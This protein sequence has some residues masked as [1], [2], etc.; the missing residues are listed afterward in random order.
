MGEF[1]TP[2]D[3]KKNR[4]L[5]WVKIPEL[6]TPKDGQKVGP[7]GGLSL[8]H[9]YEGGRGVCVVVQPRNMGCQATC[10]I[11]SQ[12]QVESDQLLLHMLVYS[13]KVGGQTATIM[14]PCINI[15]THAHIHPHTHTHLQHTCTH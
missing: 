6:G 13:D 4:F 2:K 10:A 8:S 9:P 1:G 12:F 5:R 14:I 3:G 11:S 7:A 15:E